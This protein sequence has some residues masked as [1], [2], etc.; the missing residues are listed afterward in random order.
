MFLEIENTTPDMPMENPS[1]AVIIMPGSGMLLNFSGYSKGKL[2]EKEVYKGKIDISVKYG[3][4]DIGYTRTMSRWLHFHQTMK[5]KIPEGAIP[6]LTMLPMRQVA[7]NAGPYKEDEDK[8]Y[9]A[10]KL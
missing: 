8:P 4:P 1:T 10:P 6:G 3:H 9:I 2:P 5:P 7:L